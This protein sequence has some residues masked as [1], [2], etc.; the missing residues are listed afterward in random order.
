MNHTKYLHRPG[1]ALLQGWEQ[2]VPHQ[3][4]PIFGVGSGHAYVTRGAIPKWP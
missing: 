4:D 1:Q 3:R 2:S